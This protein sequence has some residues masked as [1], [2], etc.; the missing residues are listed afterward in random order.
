ME[1]LIKS[2]ELE[3]RHRID[4]FD[5]SKGIAG[6]C[7]QVTVIARMIISIDDLFSEDDNFS[8]N[9][10]SVPSADEIKA[11]LGDTVTF[12]VKKQ[13]NFIDDKEKAAVFDQLLETFI[14]FSAPYL[15]HPAFAL[16]FVLKQYHAKKRAY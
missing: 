4:I 12:E 13:R 6:D 1:H 9:K 8:N 14:K 3:N 7:W 2:I 16:K 15:S 11:V 5:A 10:I